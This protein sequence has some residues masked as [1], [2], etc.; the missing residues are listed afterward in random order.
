MKSKDM[1]RE[2]IDVFLKVFG[3]LKQ[4]VLW[5]FEDDLAGK[6]E[7]VKIGAWLP[8]NDILGNNQTFFSAAAAINDFENCDIDSKK[9]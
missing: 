8:Q 9:N 2:K 3:R 4:K 5:K 1:P 7:N 6:P